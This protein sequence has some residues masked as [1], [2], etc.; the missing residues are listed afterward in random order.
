[1]QPKTVSQ[2][3]KVL[4]AFYSNPQDPRRVFNPSYIQ[5]AG[6]LG[7]LISIAGPPDTAS[8]NPSN[9]CNV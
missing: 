8:E 2:L 4:S 9:K 7:S 6:N 1:M 5:D 3:Q